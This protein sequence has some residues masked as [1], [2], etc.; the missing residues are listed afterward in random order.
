MSHLR[1]TCDRFVGIVS[2]TGETNQA[3]SA[4]H[5]FRVGKWVANHVI[6]W[7][8]GVETIKRQTMATDGC[9]AAGQSPVDTG[10]AYGL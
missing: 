3:N 6:T 2:A 10:L 7:I 9:L 4:Y 5:P 1:V 8:T